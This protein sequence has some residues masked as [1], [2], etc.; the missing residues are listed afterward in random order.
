MHV[1][2]SRLSGTRWILIAVPFSLLVILLT[3]SRDT[4]RVP[5]EY[6]QEKAHGYLDQTF[7]RP[8]DDIYDCQDPY[9]GPG[10]LYMPYEH[11]DY[12]ET[13]WIPYTSDLF[14]AETPDYAEYPPNQEV[15]FNVTE[16][17][18]DFLD[19]ASVPQEWMHKAVAENKRRRRAV[20]TLEPDPEKFA[21]M[22]DDGDLSWLWGRR[23]LLIS[24]S[25]D[26]FMTKYFCQEFDEVMWQGE[27][28]SVSTCTIPALNLTVNHWFAVGQFT[29]TPKWW[30][31]KAKVPIVAW[32][33]RWEEVYSPMNDTI[34]GPTGLPDLVI[35]QNGIWDQRT[36]R[37]A[38]DAHY[39]K[40]DRP[41]GR[42]ARQMVWQEVRFMAARINKFVK[43]LED[44]FPGVP[45]MFR[46]LTAHSHAPENGDL[47]VHELDR[48]Q[49]A[50]ATN[51][52]H[53]VFEWGRILTSF[54]SLYMDIT[55]P[56]KGPAS[57]LWDNMLLEY[58]ARSAG[59]GKGD[60]KQ[61]P[62]FDGWDTCH[63]YLVNWG[64]R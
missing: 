42:H 30:W 56:G 11:A 9:R 33:E 12:K 17:E 23:V 5:L 47:I 28:N 61:P 24:D 64:G 63:P 53:E 37:T 45:I 21:H 44:V 43:H 34:R 48:L 32:E 57:W 36:L 3:F 49:R 39:S 18:P 8:K 22:K 40:K 51:A 2:K 20:H 25:V 55:H 54:G 46:A 62:Y 13:R 19:A 41:L 29:Y 60:A 38:S 15:W 10:Y 58:V 1:P 16:V 52:G 27:G 50:A 7:H 6:A 31:M 59:M 4:A 14:D 26:R 35:W